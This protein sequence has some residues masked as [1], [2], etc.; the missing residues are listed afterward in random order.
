[1]IFYNKS[2]IKAI[3]KKKN[4]EDETVDVDGRSISI[5]KINNAIR[6]PG[7]GRRPFAF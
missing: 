5:L 3:P 2:G 7:G 4:K 6:S 1:M